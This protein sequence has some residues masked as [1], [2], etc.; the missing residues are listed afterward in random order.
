MA[1]DDARRTPL[2][3]MAKLNAMASKQALQAVRE[4]AAIRDVLIAKGLVSADEFAQ[5]MRLS[6]HLSQDLERLVDQ[7]EAPLQGEDPE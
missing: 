6:E 2:E 1:D 4:V 7:L 3:A 5:S